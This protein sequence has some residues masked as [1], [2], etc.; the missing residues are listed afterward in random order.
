[1]GAPATLM[2]QTLL[3]PIRRPRSTVPRA[4]DPALA[5]YTPRSLPRAR[6]PALATPRSTKSHSL[7]CD[8]ITLVELREILFRFVR[9]LTI[10]VVVVDVP[11]KRAAGMEG[12]ER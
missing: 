12:F 9:I 10:A 3:T 1:M 2:K 6:H 11:K 8:E 5:T 7:I 4:R